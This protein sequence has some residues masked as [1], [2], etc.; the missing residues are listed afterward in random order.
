MGI[1]R[2]NPETVYA[3]TNDR[4]SQVVKASGNTQ[5]HVSGMVGQTREGELV[6]EDMRE[7][8]AQT[9][10]MISNALDAASADVSDIVRVRILT[11]DVDEYLARCHELTVDWYGEDKPASTLEEVAGLATDKLKVEIEVTAITE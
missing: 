3:P 6:S 2:F 11:T 1:Q 9:L 8:T 7:Q 5:I 4:Y 10:E